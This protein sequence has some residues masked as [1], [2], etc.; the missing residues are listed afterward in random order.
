M[1]SFGDWGHDKKFF[2]DGDVLLDGGD[3]DGEAAVG[4]GERPLKRDFEAAGVAV[5]RVIDL[6]R[7]AA[8]R[9]RWFT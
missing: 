2:V 7:I 9:G 3:A 6:S 4:T 8:E 5:I 1:G